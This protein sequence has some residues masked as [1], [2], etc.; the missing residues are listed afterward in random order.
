MNTYIHINIYTCTHI[1]TYMY[2]H[3]NI[4]HIHLMDP[5]HVV[6]LQ[7]FEGREGDV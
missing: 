3:L 2:T 7:R 4:L 1:Y 5:I 6:G